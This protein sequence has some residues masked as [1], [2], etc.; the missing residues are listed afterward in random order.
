MGFAR[1]SVR[2]FGCLYISLSVGL[3]HAAN[4]KTKV[5]ENWH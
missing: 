4:S 2:L 5:A 3:V 1:L